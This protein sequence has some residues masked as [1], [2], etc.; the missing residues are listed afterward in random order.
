MVRKLLFPALFGLLTGASSAWIGAC[1]ADGVDGGAGGAGGGGSST[2]T[3]RSDASVDVA[4]DAEQPPGPI[5]YEALC[6][7]GPCVPGVRGRP[8]EPP[9]TSTGTG[10]GGGAS[11]SGGG[12]Q[13]GAGGGGQGG[14]GGFEPVAYGCQVDVSGAE[15]ESVCAPIDTGIA[16]GA[17]CVASSGCPEGA[18]CA[19]D[20]S[21]T[22]LAY[23]CAD[24]DCPTEHFC[25]P[26]PATESFKR[27]G[28]LKIPVCKL[29]DN[30]VPFSDACPE[31]ETCTIVKSDG[32]TSCVPI[33]TG[34]ACDP[35]PCDEGHMC[36][37]STGRCQKLCKTGHSD[38]CGGGGTCQAILPELGVCIG[39][40]AVCD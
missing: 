5:T 3:G 7:E 36:N 25:T 28:D 38:E 33:G 12:G 8:C 24:L 6:G 1:A 14:N 27:G 9:T 13:G 39:G 10:A 19:G 15:P 4:P 16:L 11:S 30:C 2:G 26:L 31:G 35:C 37:Y 34:Q 21:G 18:G 17:A 22:C 23:C 20:I 40:D 29:A 32:T